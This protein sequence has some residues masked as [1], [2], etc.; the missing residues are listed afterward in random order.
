MSESN[1]RQAFRPASGTALANSNGTAPGIDARLG[2][3]RIVLLP[4]PPH[5]MQSMF[6]EWVE[7][8]L[9]QV[10][11]TGHRALIKAYGLGESNACE[12]LGSITDRDALPQVGTRV[13]ESILSAFV[14]GRGAPEVAREIERRWWPYAFGTGSDTLESVL[15]EL[16]HARS[17][18][19]AT[20]ESCT[21]GLLGGRVTGVAGSSAWYRGG[22]VT[23]TNELKSELLGVP[24]ALIERM[25]AV[26]EQVAVV[27]AMEAARRFGA[28]FALSSTGIAGPG[29]GTEQKPVG[30]VWIGACDASGERPHAWA[31][32]FH[33]PGERE[34][35]RDRTVKSAL[36][37]L[38]LHVLSEEAPLL[39]EV[40]S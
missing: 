4:G 38:R 20:A 9:E 11:I 34:R 10:D 32:C 35:V 37:M 28:S 40:D 24:G 33:F 3:A 12:K 5:E 8:T 30:T 27:M 18:T 13:S 19:L 6:K 26:S 39:W 22:V 36:Q 31:K 29:G 7:P 21:G 2:D 17:G 1:R 25:G 14:K 15:G 16:L 23:Y